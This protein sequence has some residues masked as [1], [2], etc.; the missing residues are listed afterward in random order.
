MSPIPNLYLTRRP[1]HGPQ[2][3]GDSSNSD[4]SAEAPV[5]EPLGSELRA[6][7][8]YL[9]LPTTY[10]KDQASC[11]TPSLPSEYS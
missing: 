6:L 7:R 3:V 10:S 9:P 4:S 11:V 5:P 1:V 8:F 2:Q